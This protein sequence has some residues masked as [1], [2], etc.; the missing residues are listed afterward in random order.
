V[1]C[2]R[3]QEASVSAYV[4]VVFVHI[5]A[6]VLLLGTSILGE[7]AVRA[8]ARRA[9]EPHDLRAFLAIGRPMAVLSPLAAVLLLASGVY[10]AS[11]AH[12]WTLG[13]IQVATAFWIVNC[14]VAVAVVK[15]AIGRVAAEATS[16]TTS[17]GPDL[18]RLRWSRAWT[19][20]VDLLAANDAAVLYLMT[21]KP[22]LGGSLAIVILANIAVAGGRVVLG[23]H[24]QRVTS[25]TVAPGS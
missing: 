10:L 6:A 19:W 11:I 1:S 7:P 18:D 2:N 21:A 16:A 25:A 22:G 8:A 23:I 5:A 14:V 15:P 4:L 9:T 20:G 13:W 3:R 24:P 12:F 17:I